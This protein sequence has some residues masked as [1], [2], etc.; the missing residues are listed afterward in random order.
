MSRLA[1]LYSGLFV[2][3]LLLP[4]TSD[5]ARLA[6]PNEP[7][8]EFSAS[9]Q[10]EAP[11]ESVL[12]EV[13]PAERAAESEWVES[14]NSANI[15]LLIRYLGSSDEIAQGMA[16]AEFAG[17]GPKAK[18]AVPAILAALS[19]PKCLIRVEAAATLIHMDVQSK[20]AIRAL[21]KELKAED[22]AARAHAVWTIGQLVNPP[23]PLCT[24]CW[25]PDPPPWVARPWV[26][27]QTL[28]TLVEVLTDHDPN[29]RATVAHTVGLIGPNARPAVPALTKALKDEEEA[30]RETAKVSLRRI[31]RRAS[32]TRVSSP[33]HSR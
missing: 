2:L 18:P 17:M 23:P 31:N 3:M 22:A 32:P 26:G 8:D 19:D 5:P 6:P 21:R 1:I 16:L 15:P 27:K 11:R 7:L 14:G 30:V 20:A 12:E 33:R 4:S 24:G 29:L 28:P 25:G 13:I 10:L 9:V